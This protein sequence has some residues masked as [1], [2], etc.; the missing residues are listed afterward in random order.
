MAPAMGR[1]MSTPKLAMKKAVPVRL[2]MSSILQTR[3]MQTGVIL[4]AAP[5]QKPYS[6]VK[7]YMAASLVPAVY[8]SANIRA[9]HVVEQMASTLKA[10]NR[11]AA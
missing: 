3:L 9:A 1:P 10:P 5:D 2:P 8:Q 6:T 7:E 4:I 11:S